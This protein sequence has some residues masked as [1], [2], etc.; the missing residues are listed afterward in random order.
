MKSASLNSLQLNLHSCAM[1]ADYVTAIAWS[2]LGKILAVSSAVGEVMFWRDLPGSSGDADWPL[3]PLQIADGQVCLWQKA[4]RLAQVL[5][6]ATDGFSCL[7][8][9]P[10]G[11]QLAAGG[12]Q[13]ELLIWIKVMRG[14]GFGRR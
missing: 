2:P 3:L 14:Q 6:G 4:K 1:L 12:Q 8:W 9:H 11:Q 13:G 7:A 10:Q 5:H